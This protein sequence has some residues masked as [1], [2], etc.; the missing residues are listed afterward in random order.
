MFALIVCLSFTGLANAAEQATK[1]SPPPGPS[2]TSSLI[3][4][5]GGLFVVFGVFLGAI[6]LLK[7]APM[8]GRKA[9]DTRKLNVMESRN[10]A[11]RQALYVIGYERQ[12]Y[13]VASTPT[14]I[15]LLTALPAAETDEAPSDKVTT[16]SFT[17]ALMQAVQKQ[18]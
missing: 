7:R 4:L 5:V 17:E 15:S 3:R 14:G 18:G 12:R 1:L 11:P 16:A 10:L 6:W 8:L 2:L 13:L 9:G